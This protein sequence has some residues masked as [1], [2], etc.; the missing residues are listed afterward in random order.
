MTLILA[1]TDQFGVSEAPSSVGKVG[2]HVARLTS[3]YQRYYYSG[4][5][6]E[7][8]ARAVLQQVEG[9]LVRLR[10]VPGCDG[11]GTR[12]RH[13]HPPGRGRRRS[14]AMDRVRAHD[15]PPRPPAAVRRTRVPIGVT[16]A[17]VKM[18]VSSEPTPADTPHGRLVAPAPGD[19]PSC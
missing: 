15:P 6:S 3:E 11:A 12:G 9:A 17:A 19:W 16:D 13:R 2:E 4:I 1:V 8:W 18:T 5:V 7:R 14:A 10:R